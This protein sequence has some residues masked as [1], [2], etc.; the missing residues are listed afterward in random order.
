MGLNRRLGLVS[1]DV[2]FND[3][4]WGADCLYQ[5]EVEVGGGK[6]GFAVLRS[7]CVRL[8]ED[9][10]CSSLRERMRSVSVFYAF[11]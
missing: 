9:D 5:L 8:Y 10:Y 7:R 2:G 4:F 11:A 1:R 6:L 3:R